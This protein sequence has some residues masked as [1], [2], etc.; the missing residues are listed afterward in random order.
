MRLTSLAALL[1]C[2]AAAACSFHPSDGSNAGDGGDTTDAAID[3]DACV[4]SGPET[5]EGTDED[6]DGMID[7]GL[8]TGAPCDGPDADQCPDDMTICNSTGAVVCGNTSGDDDVERCNGADDDCDGMMDEG[9]MVAATCDGPDG[10]ACKEGTLGCATDG[11]S[12]VCSDTTDTILETCNGADDDCDTVIDDG[13]DLQSDEANCGECG[14]TC[15]NVHGTNTC[16]TGNCVPSCTNG[17]AECNN[18]P[19]DGCELQDTNPACSQLATA[20]ITVTGDAAQTTSIMGTTESYVKVRVR[21]SNNGADV[22]ITASLALTSGAG[23][24]YSLHVYC[25]ACGNI[26]LSDSNDNTIEVG[27]ADGT[28]DRSF[29]V[30]AEIRYVGPASTTCAPWTLTVTGAV[31]TTNRCGGVAGP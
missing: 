8:T 29:E 31:A 9:F 27:R 23:A 2:A 24:G 11:L 16:T 22:D 1:L 30:F 19:D 4:A 13:F 15:T 26:P 6:C 7:E 12:A 21:E 17:S 14:N 25:L 10:D 20:G 5:C 3:I 18:D 28:G